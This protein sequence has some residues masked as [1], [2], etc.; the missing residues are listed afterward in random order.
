M[1]YDVSREGIES[2]IENI[3]SMVTRIGARGIPKETLSLALLRLTIKL[4]KGAGIERG[5]F[6]EEAASSWESVEP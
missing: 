5:E 3:L 2:R 6:L 4:A 1:A